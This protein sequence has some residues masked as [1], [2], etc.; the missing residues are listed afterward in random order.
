MNINL[1]KIQDHKKNV[2]FL[3]KKKQ[4]YIN[5]IIKSFIINKYSSI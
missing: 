5:P 4:L 1:V 2:K 3:E